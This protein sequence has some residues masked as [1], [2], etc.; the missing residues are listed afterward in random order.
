MTGNEVNTE[1]LASSPG[2]L[3]SIGFLVWLQRQPLTRLRRPTGKTA[4]AW[5]SDQSCR[6]A[7]VMRQRIR[8][9]S[10]CGSCGLATGP[11]QAQHCRN[12][13]QKLLDFGLNRKWVVHLTSHENNVVRE[14]CQSRK[15]P[16]FI[17]PFWGCYIN[18]YCIWDFRQRCLLA[19]LFHGHCI[20]AADARAFPH[21]RWGWDEFYWVSWGLTSR[22]SLDFQELRVLASL[23]VCSPENFDWKSWYF[24]FRTSCNP[25]FSTDPLVWRRRRSLWAVGNVWWWAWRMGAQ[26]CRRGRRQQFLQYSFCKDCNVSTFFHVFFCCSF[27]T[28]PLGRK[29]HDF[30]WCFAGCDCDHPGS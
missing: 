1:K 21:H 15:L 28:L 7:T 30:H 24:F 12:W 9:S 27:S 8:Y 22:V 13:D 29:D 19:S 4:V 26:F 18:V 20:A 16:T 23:P 11:T 3:S 10:S 14:I 17:S 5:R 6:C 2:L 25:M